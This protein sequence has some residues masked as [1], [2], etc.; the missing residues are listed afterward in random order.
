MTTRQLADELGIS[1]RAIA[2]QIKKLQ[3]QGLLQRIGPD[4]GHWEVINKDKK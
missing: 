3:E 2:K 1:H 4:K